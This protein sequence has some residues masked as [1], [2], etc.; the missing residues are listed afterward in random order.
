[1]S[2]KSNNN[3]DIN[4]SINSNSNN[5]ITDRLLSSM[6]V[7]S[8]ERPRS[9]LRKSMDIESHCAEVYGCGSDEDDYDYKNENN[10][11][12]SSNNNNNSN[13]IDDSFHRLRENKGYTHDFDFDFDSDD[14]SF[15]EA[16]SDCYPDQY[17][18]DEMLEEIHPERINLFEYKKKEQQQHRDH[19]QVHVQD[20]YNEDH[21]IDGD[22]EK[23]KV[24]GNDYIMNN[25]KGSAIGRLDASV[26][27]NL[28]NCHET[29]NLFTN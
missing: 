27:N 17:Y 28:N 19:D 23:E 4:R 8:R 12:K 6:S 15:A 10:N 20:K 7:S 26:N 24:K 16:D 9:K 3:D 18:L 2:K 13:T 11:N 22:D 21:D 29:R 14:D 25:G 5:A 1:M